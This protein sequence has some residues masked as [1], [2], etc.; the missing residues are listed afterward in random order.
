VK[1]GQIDEATFTAHN[2]APHIVQHGFFVRNFGLGETAIG[3]RVM[4]TVPTE[5]PD[6]WTSGEGST[7][8][9]AI[10]KDQEVFAPLWRKLGGYLLGHVLSRFDL[11]QFLVQT[12][13]GKFG[14]REVPVTIRY[15]SNG[16]RYVT[17]QNLIYSP[18]QRDIVGFGDPVQTLDA[19][20]SQ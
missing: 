5:V 13:N 16:K 14:N 18:E 3:V 10:G 2:K 11:R 6:V 19:E 9:L 1:W 17:T 7:P 12:Y 20:P 4:L 8:S 15:S